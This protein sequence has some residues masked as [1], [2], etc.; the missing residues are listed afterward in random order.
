MISPKRQIRQGIIYGLKPAGKLIK[1]N[2][3]LKR[4]VRNLVLEH[5]NLV[6]GAE[7]SRYKIWLSFHNPDG[8]AFLESKTELNNFDYRPLISILTPT[9][10]TDIEHLYECLMSVKAQ[11]YENWELCIV[12]DASTDE[13]VRDEIKRL[14]DTDCCIKY[15]FRN[16]NGHISEA[17][18][19]ALKMAKGEYIGLLDHDDILW[20]NALFEMIKALNSKK[21]L[22]FLYSDE[23]KIRLN[24]SDHQNPFFK[25]D[26]NPEFLESVN[27]ITHFAVIR[28]KLV[29]K[30]G[31]FRSRYDGAQDWDLFLRVCHSTKQIHHVP[32]VLYSW[33]MSETSTASSTSAKPYVTEAQKAAIAESLKVRDSSSAKVVRGMAKDYWSVVYP[34]PKRAKVSIVIPTKNQAAIVKRCIESIYRR[35]TYKNFE[36]ILVDTGSTSKR[37]INWYKRLEKHY[38]NINILYWPEQPFSYARACNF[39][40]KNATG[41]YLVMLNNDTEIITP[42]WLELLISDAQRSDVGPVGCKLYYPG[43]KRIQHAGIGIGFGGVAANSLSLLHNNE[44]SPIQHLYANTRHEVS[45]VTAAC[46]MIKKE[47]FDEV[48]GFDEKF[49]ITY[50]DVDLCLRLGKVGYRSI[51]NP[52][53]ELIHYESISLGMPSEKKKRDTVEFKQAKDLF[54]SRWGKII[55]HDPHLN[56]NIDRNNALFEIGIS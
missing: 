2:P 5:M 26:W 25:P 31:G 1:N 13:A 47:R 24:R 16:T 10:N 39:G 49:R 45:A 17:T 29:E 44:L 50:N 11:W 34:I 48:G 12:D 7:N 4:I 27:Y 38:K 52:S 6:A 9:Y 28:K 3:K 56:P 43:G 21:S 55:N 53:V 51:Y 8:I 36:I 35:T 42:E 30:V 14:A 22:D 20:P 15:T 40:A 54:V 32:T 46:L 33:R 19:D 37:V 41:E 23:D 18:N